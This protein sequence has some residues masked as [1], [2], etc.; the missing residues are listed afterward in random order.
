MKTA[1]PD[2]IRIREEIN[3]EADLRDPTRKRI[4]CDVN[5]VADVDFHPLRLQI[6]GKSDAGL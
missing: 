2:D 4:T 3:T 6:L 1:S 5:A